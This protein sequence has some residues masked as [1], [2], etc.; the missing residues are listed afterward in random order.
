MVKPC[1]NRT[2]HFNQGLDLWSMVSLSSH[3]T[4]EV[5]GHLQENDV[6]D[7]IAYNATMTACGNAHKWTQVTSFDGNAGNAFRLTV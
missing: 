1:L 2:A 6:A 3:S 4:L 7:V 5:F